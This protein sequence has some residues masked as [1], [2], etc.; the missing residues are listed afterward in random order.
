MCR[1]QRDVRDHE[2]L[3]RS[4]LRIHSPGVNYDQ[5]QPLKRPGRHASNGSPSLSVSDNVLYLLVNIFTKQ[6]ISSVS[7]KPTFL[8]VET[9]YKWLWRLS[10][11]V[12]HSDWDNLLVLNNNTTEQKKSQIL[13]TKQFHQQQWNEDDNPTLNYFRY[14]KANLLLANLIRRNGEYHYRCISQQDI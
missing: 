2:S 9:T 5:W 4:I 13:F 6:F 14:H 7:L 3:S 8:K 1:W 10:L 11:T 12:H